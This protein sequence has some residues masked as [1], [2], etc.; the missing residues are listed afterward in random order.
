M[1]VESTSVDRY[2]R[3]MLENPIVIAPNASEEFAKY[4]CTVFLRCCQPSRAKGECDYCL[5]PNSTLRR[6]DQFRDHFFR[7]C[8]LCAI[9]SQMMAA[10]A[11]HSKT[12]DKANDSKSK[13]VRNVS[14]PLSF[15]NPACVT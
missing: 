13:V 15:S 9:K 7:V 8:A 14:C 4:G 10:K 12:L 2:Q 11:L 1:T 5:N 6:V 3:L